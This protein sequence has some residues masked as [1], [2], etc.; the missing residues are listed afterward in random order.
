MLGAMA[1]AEAVAVLGCMAP[2]AAV[3]L[4]RQLPTDRLRGLTAL[5]SVHLCVMLLDQMERSVVTAVLSSLESKKA[6]SVLRF[7]EGTVATEL[8]R[9]YLTPTLLSSLVSRLSISKGGRTWAL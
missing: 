3:M 6:N 8:T 2:D 7:M 4:C 9:T 1:S 5:M